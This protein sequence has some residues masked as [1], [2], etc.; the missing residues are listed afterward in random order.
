MR[1][2]RM[3]ALSVVAALLTILARPAEAVFPRLL[4]VYGGALAR[5]LIVESPQDVQRIFEEVSEG[6]DRNGLNRRPYF[7]LALFWGNDVWDR[8]VHEGRLSQLKPE[9]A[10]SELV[11]MRG[12]PIRGRFF[13]ACAE[14]P[15]QIT[16]TEVNSEAIQS[17]WRVSPEGLQ[18]LEKLGVP[19]RRDCK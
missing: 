10:T 11:P 12:I 4:M 8:Y 15:A 18:V 13:P 16:L 3:I 9:D 14:A 5:P 1:P 2:S 6:V 19:I 17:I 7:E